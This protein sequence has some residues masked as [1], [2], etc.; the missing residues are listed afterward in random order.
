MSVIEYKPVAGLTIEQALRRAWTKAYRNYTTVVA[1]VNDVIMCVTPETDIKEA[2][3]SYNK[4]LAFKHE[5]EKLKN[6][7]QK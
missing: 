1:N 4:R 3:K 7:K 5:I 6:E 2:M